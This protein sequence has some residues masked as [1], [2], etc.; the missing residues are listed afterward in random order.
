L[1]RRPLGLDR[2][3]D[4]NPIR[5]S[6]N[7]AYSSDGQVGAVI[8]FLLGCGGCRYEKHGDEDEGS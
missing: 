5:G 3:K 8:V 2:E 4:A 7:L 1:G 6:V